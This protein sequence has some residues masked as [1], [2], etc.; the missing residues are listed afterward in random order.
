[1][2]RLLALLLARRRDRVLRD[3]GVLVGTR[4]YRRALNRKEW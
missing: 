4:A 1:M 3:A 2:S